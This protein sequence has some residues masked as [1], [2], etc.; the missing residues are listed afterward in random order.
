MATGFRAV[1]IDPV[2]CTV[3]EVQY[4]GLYTNIYEHIEADCFDVARINA[5]GDGVFIDDEGLLKEGQSFF[6]IEGYPTP[7]AGKGLV[8]GTDK[9]G[10]SVEPT[11]TLE[12]VRARVMFVEPVRIGGKVVW[13]VNTDTG[14]D[15]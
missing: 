4:T 3:S 5:K 13:I 14:E 11:L 1:L 6:L 10:E 12:E 8:L 7:L 15:A 2:A 9:H